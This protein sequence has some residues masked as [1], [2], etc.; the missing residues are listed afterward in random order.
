MGNVNE[1]SATLYSLDERW[2]TVTDTS[3]EQST[4][5]FWSHLLSFNFSVAA[6]VLARK[7]FGTKRGNENAFCVQHRFNVGHCFR[8]SGPTRARQNISRRA[9]SNFFF[10]RALPLGSCA[11]HTTLCLF[12]SLPQSRSCSPV[13]KFVISKGVSV[14]SWLA[15]VGKAKPSVLTFRRRNFH[16]NLITPSI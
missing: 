2:V 3:R 4:R 13:L 8:G 15:I 11:S 14:L 1:N 12:F 9:F 16:L 5:V 10:L 6:S 7:K